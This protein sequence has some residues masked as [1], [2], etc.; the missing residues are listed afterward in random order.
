VPPFFKRT[1]S[2]QIAE[3]PGLAGSTMIASTLTSAASAQG[4]NAV[5]TRSAR[6]KVTEILIKIA[7][8]RMSVLPRVVSHPGFPFWPPGLGV[9]YTSLPPFELFEHSLSSGTPPAAPE[10]AGSVPA[11]S[12]FSVKIS[13]LRSPGRKKDTTPGTTPARLPPELQEAAGQVTE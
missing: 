6:Q 7:T 1:L 9:V 2:L 3:G 12:D 5:S 10:R 11:A 4:A 8:I 13:T